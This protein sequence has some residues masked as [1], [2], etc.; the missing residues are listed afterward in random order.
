LFFGSVN[1]IRQEI[2]LW[3]ILIFGIQLALP[4]AT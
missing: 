3:G 4:T 2:V 1:G